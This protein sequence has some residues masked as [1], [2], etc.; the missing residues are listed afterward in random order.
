MNPITKSVT[1]VEFILTLDLH[2]ISPVV[3]GYAEMFYF[4]R[5]SDATGNQR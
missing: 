1:W 5:M 3:P 4:S 2:A